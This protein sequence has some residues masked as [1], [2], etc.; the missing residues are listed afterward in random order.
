MKWWRE[1]WWR[2]QMKGAVWSGL[3]MLKVMWVPPSAQLSLTARDER[4]CSHVGRGLI[5][6]PDVRLHGNATGQFRVTSAS[7]NIN[8]QTNR[9]L[10]S[11]NQSFI[12]RIFEIK[13]TNVHL[14]HLKEYISR[15]WKWFF[16]FLTPH[17]RIY[18]YTRKYWNHI[19]QHH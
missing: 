17:W 18:D 19:Y 7:T 3:M 4:P 10:L 6:E 2:S 9:N 13:H 11:F 15:R 5:S 1:V 12:K 16:T 8:T 14:I